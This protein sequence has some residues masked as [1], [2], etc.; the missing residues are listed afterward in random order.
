MNPWAEKPEPGINA[1]VGGAL[2]GKKY[3]YKPNGL[4]HHW[5]FSE[6]DGTKVADFITVYIDRVGWRHYQPKR[7]EMSIDSTFVTEEELL[8]AVYE[9]LTKTIGTSLYE[10]LVSE[11]PVT[12]RRGL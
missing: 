1:S 3:G 4:L 6:G 9:R 7:W 8:D 10:E 2:P 12:I 5:V 11:K